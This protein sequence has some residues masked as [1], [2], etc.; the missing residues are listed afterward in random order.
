MR[1]TIPIR[2]PSLSNMRVGWREMA[3][4]KR[5]QKTATSVCMRSALNS[6][7]ELPQL[8]LLVI[9]TRIGPRKLDDDNLDGSFK[10][11]R[12]QIAAI[13]GIDDGNDQFT[14]IPRQKIGKGYSVE[15]EIMPR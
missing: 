4:L 3:G 8:P 12:D 11:V 6:G 5:R 13:V 14:W 7:A 1:F 9:M 2:L 15:V 10:Y